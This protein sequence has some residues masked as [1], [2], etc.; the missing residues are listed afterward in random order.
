MAN[1]YM[2][3]QSIL[4]RVVLTPTEFTFFPR[5][6]GDL[7]GGIAE[8][9]GQRYLLVKYSF[10]HNSWYLSVVNLATPLPRTSQLVIHIFELFKGGD[11]KPLHRRNGLVQRRHLKCESNY[12]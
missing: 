2:V 10:D 8:S 7:H 4:N 3:Q 9:L 6:L 1:S 11:I 12:D 5:Q